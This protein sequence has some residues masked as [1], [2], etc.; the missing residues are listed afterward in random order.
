MVG[1]LA[2]FTKQL[3]KPACK[4]LQNHSAYYICM[5]MHGALTSS[6]QKTYITFMLLWKRYKR[7]APSQLNNNRV[8]FHM[9]HI[10][11]VSGISAHCHRHTASTCSDVKP[12][13]AP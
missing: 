13:N 7:R 4:L 12:V 9:D 1:A 5:D 6:L 11:T 8:M 10:K 3:A 2:K